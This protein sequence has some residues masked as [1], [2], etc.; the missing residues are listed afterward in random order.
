M[1]PAPACRQEPGDAS[2]RTGSERART[3]APP[4]APLD[5]GS[6]ASRS[7]VP[8]KGGPGG[9]RFF[10]K[11]FHDSRR[12]AVPRSA[13]VRPARRSRLVQ[14]D[15]LEPEQLSARFSPE[16]QLHGVSPAAGAHPFRAREGSDPAG[17]GDPPCRWGSAEARSSTM[18]AE[19]TIYAGSFPASSSTHRDSTGS[20]HV[21]RAP[22]MYATSCLSPGRSARAM[23][24]T[25]SRT[26]GRQ[27]R[28]PRSLRARNESRGSSPAGRCGR[29]TR[30]R[31]PPGSAPGHRCGTTAL[32]GP[33]P[34]GVRNEALRRQRRAGP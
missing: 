29:G 7:W 27:Q 33:R 22:M 4:R 26:P 18:N 3:S 17:R 10:P 8:T 13:S 1:V 34:N 28:A 21:R 31:H 15:Q 24:T 12:R 5:P 14:A 20:D 9:G 30:S 23:T 19:G 11:S 25:A 16:S 2:P 32:P 6:P